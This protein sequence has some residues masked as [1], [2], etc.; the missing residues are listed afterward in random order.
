MS[1][2]QTATTRSGS[3]RDELKA[4]QQA[5]DGALEQVENLQIDIAHEKKIRARLE[6]EVR[7]CR[8]CSTH[9]SHT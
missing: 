2:L 1:R 5:R 7:R 9:S 4:A 3:L 8:V 6:V